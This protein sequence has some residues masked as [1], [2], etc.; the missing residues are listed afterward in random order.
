[1]T[2]RGVGAEGRRCPLRGAVR[3]RVRGARSDT[4]DAGR[5][6]AGADL[7]RSIRVRG[8]GA[9]GRVR[10][11]NSRGQHARACGLHPVIGAAGA[12]RFGQRSGATQ[13]IRTCRGRRLQRNVRRLRGFVAMCRLC[14]GDARTARMGRGIRR[15]RA[16]RQAG[17]AADRQRRQYQHERGGDTAARDL[18]PPSISGV[19]TRAV[20]RP[21]SHGR[22][23]FALW[24]CWR[25]VVSDIYLRLTIASAGP[26]P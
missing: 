22:Q 10:K 6:R 8:G 23:R 11:R 20:C 18:H 4:K 9:S 16:E 1:M 25:R 24:R 26:A 21:H 19:V 12:R 15:E 14:R 13:S 2:S 5:G 7:R 3:G 17:R